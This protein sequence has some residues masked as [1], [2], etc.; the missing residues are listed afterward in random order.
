MSTLPS[1]FV[2]LHGQ[3]AAAQPSDFDGRLA[4]AQRTRAEHAEALQR[5]GRGLILGGF[6]ITITGVVGYCVASFAGGMDA[7]MGDILFRNSVPF[8]R[9]TLAVL[10]VGTL[11]WLAGSFT[12]L[13]GAMDA[14]EESERG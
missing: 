11:V 8:A 4:A 5:R 9:A 13:K 6:V 12:Y 7:D 2:G 10:G 14:D 3:E 1:Q